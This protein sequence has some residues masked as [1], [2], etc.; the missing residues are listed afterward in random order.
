MPQPACGV[1]ER[2]EGVMLA[3]LA[4]LPAP[5]PPASFPASRGGRGVLSAVT[6]LSWW[7]WI[8]AF[9]DLSTTCLL[10]FKRA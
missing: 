6:L 1:T 7:I 8:H 9:D 3:A 4:T 5:L 2:G 10:S